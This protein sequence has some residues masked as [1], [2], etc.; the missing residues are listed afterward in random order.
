MTIYLN[1]TDNGQTIDEEVKGVS[2]RVVPQIHD[3]D[4]GLLVIDTGVQGWSPVEYVR[5]NDQWGQ[6][7]HKM[8]H[9]HAE[10][11]NW[12]HQR[13]PSR[14]GEYA[15]WVAGD[16]PD[17]NKIYLYWDDMANLPEVEYGLWTQEGIRMVNCE[18]ITLNIKARNC[19]IGVWTQNCHGNNFQSL[20]AAYCGRGILMHQSTN[21]YFQ[22]VRMRECGHFAMHFTQ[23]SNFNVVKELQFDNIGH[24]ESTGALY[25]SADANENLVY[26]VVGSRARFG[27]FWPIDGSG[28]FFEED[29][30]N[31]LVLEAILT[32]MF[33]AVQDNSGRK[34]NTIRR[35]IANNCVQSLDISDSS[36]HGESTIPENIVLDGVLINS[37]NFGCRTAPF[38]HLR[39]IGDTGP[40]PENRWSYSFYPDVPDDTFRIRDDGVD[41][42]GPIQPWIQP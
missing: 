25:F 10:F 17:T 1:H 31:N 28:I 40:A 15:T 9:F 3:I 34:G 42:Q 26:R 19:G 13:T 23:S 7:V 11:D 33:S 22:Q 6:L 27:R 37:G 21:N 4:K 24:C 30:R 8:N 35:L 20:D 12:W 32:N 5:I 38:D 39:I 36:N 41:V 29:V 16:A 14:V 2:T 18:D